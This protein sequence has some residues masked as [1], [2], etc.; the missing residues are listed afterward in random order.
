LQLIERKGLVD[1]AKINAELAV[2]G[3]ESIPFRIFW[4]EFEHRGE[5]VRQ[6]KST[7]R[8]MRRFA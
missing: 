1:I 4:P 8:V 7:G 3:F 6:R 5:A 2:R